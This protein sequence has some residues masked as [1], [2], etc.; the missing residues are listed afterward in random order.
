M[1]AIFSTSTT[2]FFEMLS[3]ISAFSFSSFEVCSFSSRNSSRI[4]FSS[5]FIEVINYFFNSNSSLSSERRSFSISNDFS[6]STSFLFSYIVSSLSS[7]H[8]V[9]SWRSSDSRLLAR[10][11]AYS[12]RFKSWA[13]DSTFS[14][15]L[16]I[17]LAYI[18]AISLSYWSNCFIKLSF[19]I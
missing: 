4:F 3:S 2:V 6:T 8:P 14:V 18:T 9:R 12:K 5:S 16:D 7:S 19:S 1:V 13:F 15:T 11:L 10:E 17:W